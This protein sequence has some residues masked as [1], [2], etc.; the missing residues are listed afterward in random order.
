MAKPFPSVE[1]CKA[2]SLPESAFLYEKLFR[3]EENFMLL[4]QFLE[5][6]DKHNS[7]VDDVIGPLASIV[8]RGVNEINFARM[9]LCPEIDPGHVQGELIPQIR[10]F[11]FNHDWLD[12]LDG[13]ASVPPPK[14]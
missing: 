3:L 5:L 12:K 14:K 13:S 9:I 6:A 4:W 1:K 2:L 10:Q 11:A 8:E 7:S